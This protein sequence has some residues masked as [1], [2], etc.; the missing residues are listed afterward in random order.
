MTVDISVYGCAPRYSFSKAQIPPLSRPRLVSLSL[1]VRASNMR[2][3]ILA[4]VYHT[5]MGMFLALHDDN[6]NGTG[7]LGRRPARRLRPGGR[8]GFHGNVDQHPVRQIVFRRRGS[9]GGGESPLLERCERSILPA[10]GV[11]VSA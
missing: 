7:V 9:W 2:L 6:A 4:R 5:C 1:P 11:H 3:F 8:A 10:P